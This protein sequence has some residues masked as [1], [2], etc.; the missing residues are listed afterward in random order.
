MNI[1]DCKNEMSY[2][3]TSKH[4]EY[5]AEWGASKAIKGRNQTEGDITILKYCN[6]PGVLFNPVH[7]ARCAYTER[8]FNIEQYPNLQIHVKVGEID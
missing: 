7:Y 3:P 5:L 4:L 2:P 6:M 8:T 1:H